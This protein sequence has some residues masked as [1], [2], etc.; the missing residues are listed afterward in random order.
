MAAI[1]NTLESIS[2]P[3]RV[4]S[5]RG[6]RIGPRALGLV[7]G[8]RGCMPGDLSP[9]SHITGGAILPSEAHVVMQATPAALL[10]VDFK[11]GVAFASPHRRRS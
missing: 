2:H 4:R 11:Q 7:P 5:S 1:E 6:P 10:V 9:L 3:S 8:G